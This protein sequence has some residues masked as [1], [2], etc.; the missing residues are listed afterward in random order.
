ME[1]AIR[2]IALMGLWFFYT[3]CIYTHTHTHTPKV[4]SFAFVSR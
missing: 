2:G 1:E 4:F 3:M